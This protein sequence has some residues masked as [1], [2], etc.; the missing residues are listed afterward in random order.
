VST[1]QPRSE[2][3]YDGIVVGSG[4]N[5]LAAAIT[6]A[7][8]GLS[9]LLV[10]GSDSVGG[11]TRTRELTLPGFRHDVCSAIHPLAL[12]SPFFRSLDL[13]PYGLRWIQP[14]VPLAHPL[15]DGKPV[16]LHRS[17]D[18][19]AQGLGADRDAYRRLLGPLIARWEQLVYDTLRP[20][21][22]PRY[23]RTLLRFGPL[24][25][26]SAA[27]LARA[28]FQGERARALFAGNGC[29]SILPLERRSTAA[30]GLMLSIFGHT[31]GWPLAGGGSQAVA[32]ALASYLMSLGGE[33]T[34]GAPVRSLED[35]PATRAIL[36]DVTPRQLLVIAGSRLPAAYRKRL[37]SFRYGSGVFKVDWA[38]DGPIPWND[39]ACLQAGTLHIG[40]TLDEIAKAELDVERGVA[41]ERPFVLLSQ[42]TLFDADRAP[43]GMH[44]VWAYCHVPNGSTTDMTQAIELQI[45]RFARGF[46]NRIMAR[47]VMFPADMEAYNPNYIGGS[48]AGGIQSLRHL[49]VRPLGRWRP[50]TIP[51]RG[52]YLCSSSMPPGAGVH[53]MCG[54]FAAKRAMRDL[55]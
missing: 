40:G 31:V 39:P 35:L 37:E 18:L 52:V 14:P 51:A 33:V 50:Y 6:F 44:T 5:G 26:Q 1:K 12:T 43:E 49:F 11:G 29:H 13:A 54:Y 21:G 22:V 9:V 36:L 20:L 34:L 38:L 45:E 48:I 42:P 46:S 7:R 4:P 17:L 15:D 3:G 41:P 25:V 19:T 30:F 47:H 10:E 27:G 28:R 24:A 16:L 23:P 55:R 2:K 8:A 53:G 32:D